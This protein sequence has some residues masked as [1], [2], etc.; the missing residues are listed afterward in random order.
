MLVNP[1]SL[2]VLVFVLAAA[3]TGSA[4]NTGTLSIVGRNVDSTDAKTFGLTLVLASKTWTVAEPG[5]ESHF[6]KTK[7]GGFIYVPG[8]NTLFLCKKQ[9]VLHCAQEPD[10]QAGQLIPLNPSSAKP[11]ATGTGKV[12]ETGIAFKWQVKQRSLDEVTLGRTLL[13]GS[14][15]DAPLIQ[16][17]QKH[18]TVFNHDIS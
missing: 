12:E 3:R 6:F 9:D 5:N 17:S 11:G 2:L 10:S 7:K 16:C 13:T 8:I 4:D 15:L 1:K 14:N 18:H